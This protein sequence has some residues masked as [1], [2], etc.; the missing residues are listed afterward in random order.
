MEGGR[1]TYN[2]LIDRR[3]CISEFSKRKKSNPRKVH[4]NIKRRN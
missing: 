4:K 2:L 3:N 1:H